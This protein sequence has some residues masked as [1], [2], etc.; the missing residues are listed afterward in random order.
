MCPMPVKFKPEVKLIKLDIE[1]KPLD[2]SAFN[3]LDKSA[4]IR[5]LKKGNKNMKTFKFQ[6]GIELSFTEDSTELDCATVVSTFA[7]L[8]SIREKFTD[9]NLNGGTFDGKSVENVVFSGITATC[10]SNGNI[11]AHFTSRKKSREEVLEEQV[12]ELQ[13]TIATMMAK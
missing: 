1:L 2:K 6:D 4:I 13:A 5:Y 3:P 11:T 7:E 8:D 10:D 12:A 9:K